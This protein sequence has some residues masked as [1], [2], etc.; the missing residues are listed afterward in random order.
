MGITRQSATF[1]RDKCDERESTTVLSA[2][3]GEKRAD[4]WTKR[5]TIVMSKC[6]FVL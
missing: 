2:V 4:L 6:V 3:L 5:E 1:E